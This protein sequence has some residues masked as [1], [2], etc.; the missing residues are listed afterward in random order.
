MPTALVDCTPGVDWIT[1]KAIVGPDARQLYGTVRALQE[2]QARDGNRIRPW[3]ANGYTG[4]AVRH[5]RYGVKAGAVRVELS[6]DQ[7]DRYWLQLVQLATQVRRLDTKVDVTF[8]RDVGNLAQ[9]AYDAPGVPV[10][11]NLPAI[12][13]TLLVGNHGGA[14]VYVGRMGGERF[15]RVY[16][17]SAESRGEYPDH[18]W[19]WEI[20]ERNGYSDCTAGTL[21]RADD[22]PRAVAAYVS[23]FFTHHG[24]FPWFKSD[25]IALSAIHRKRRSDVSAYGDYLGRQV[26]PGVCRW[27]DRGYRDA[28]TRGLKLTAGSLIPTAELEPLS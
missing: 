1:L 28:I 5:I 26:S 20:Q 10:G 24:V 21:G 15:G 9:R 25:R 23:S 4:H 6:G 3:G 18:S 13:K 2:E 12:G 11:P 19:R 22:V 8:P 7:A 17:K 14:T 27:I 16:D